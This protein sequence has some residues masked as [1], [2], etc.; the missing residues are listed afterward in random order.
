MNEKKFHEI[1]YLHTRLSMFKDTKKMS[2]F[3]FLFYVIHIQE[4]SF[5]LDEV[6]IILQGLEYVLFLLTP[7]L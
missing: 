7:G 2:C 1:S 5:G 4:Q 6:P 3:F